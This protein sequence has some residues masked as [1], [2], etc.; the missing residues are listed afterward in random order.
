M[1]RNV[2]KLLTS[3]KIFFDLLKGIINSSVKR[4]QNIEDLNADVLNE[5]FSHAK[6][7]NISHLIAFGLTSGEVLPKTSDDYLKCQKL[8]IATMLRQEQMDYETEQ[9]CNIFEDNKIYYVPLKGTVLRKH[10]PESWMRNSCDIDILIQKNNIDTATQ[11]L[12]DRGFEYIS[13][14]THD[15]T[16]KSPHGYLFELHF[17]LN[18]EHYKEFSVLD[19]IWEHT[20]NANNTFKCIIEDEYF[21]AYHIIHMAKHFVN[22]GCGIRPFIDLWI[23]N[24][25]MP[26][27]RKKRETIIKQQ[28]LFEFEQA[29]IYQTEVWFS[30][31]KHNKT[32]QILEEYILFGGIYGTKETMVAFKQVDSGGKFQYFLSRFFLSYNEMKNIFPILKKYKWLLPFYEVK[33]WAD[34]LIYKSDY[35]MEKVRSSQTEDK[36]LNKKILYLKE[37]F[38]L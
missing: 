14:S 10:Y 19:E 16:F 35:T 31:A 6:K 9:I 21:Y 38:K 33:R 28:G 22:G 23:M 34:M 30:S 29:L 32:S 4:E 11:L 25:K 12:K 17:T 2:V 3:Q 13:K 37:K 27:D 24:N 8:L 5:V 15:I 20:A 26:Y 18:E 7:Q 1:L 36:E